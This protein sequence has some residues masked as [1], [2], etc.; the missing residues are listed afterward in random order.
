VPNIQNIKNEL[1]DI[2]TI[3]FISNAFTESSAVKI[4]NIREAFERN[5]EFYDE[6]SYVYHLVKVNAIHHKSDDAKSPIHPSP[7]SKVAKS[8]ETEKALSVALTSNQKFYG[9]INVNIMKAFVQKTKENDHSLLVIG[10]TGLESIKAQQLSKP[11]KSLIFAHDNPNEKEILNFLETIKEYNKVFMYYP[12]YLTILTQTVGVLDITFAS[13]PLGEEI[14]EDVKLIFEPELS[15]MEA[16]F[17][18]QVR[19][20]L[21]RRVLLEADLART[22]ARLVSMS[23]AEERS[24]EMI[25]EKKTELRKVRNFLINA[26]LLETFAGIKKWKHE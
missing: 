18:E 17:E 12:K 22:A 15:K 9:N 23:T 10:A 19:L 16:F 11:Y 4:K 13:S 6:V 20:L 26:R 21:F 3:K 25:K 24:D 7:I 8:K 2:T 1:D 5:R 14:Q